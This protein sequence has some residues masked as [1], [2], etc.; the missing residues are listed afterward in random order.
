MTKVTPAAEDGG[1][2]NVEETDEIKKEN[3]ADH[4]TKTGGEKPLQNNEPSTSSGSLCSEVNLVSLQIV[5][6]TLCSCV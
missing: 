3:G 1:L 6:Q 5:A 2:L 4:Q